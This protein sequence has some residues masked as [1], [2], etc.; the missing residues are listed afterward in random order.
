[1]SYFS[2]VDARKLWRLLGFDEDNL[3]ELRCVDVVGG[4]GVVG[5]GFVGSANGFVSWARKHNGAGNCFVGRNPRNKDGSV[6]H[7][8]CV[9]LDIDPFYEKTVGATPKQTEECVEAARSVLAR[10][11]GG[12]LCISGNGSLLVYTTSSP[13][14][15]GKE[16]EDKLRLFQKE[17][18]E[19][20][21]SGVKIDATQDSAR[22]IKLVGTVSVKGGARATR[23]L[24]LPACG[25]ESEE[26][27]RYIGSLGAKQPVSQADL[28]A[29]SVYPSRSEADYGFAV[30]FKQSGIGPDDCLELFA[31]NALGRNERRDDHIRI[32]EKVYGCVWDGSS[33]RVGTNT[34]AG[35]NGNDVLLLH[36]PQSSLDD[37]KAGLLKRGQDE[38]PE[39]PTGFAQ[40]DKA[41]HGLRRGEIYTIAARPA[42]GKSSMCLNI[43]RSLCANHRRVLALSTEMAYYA[44]WDR[45]FSIGCEVDGGAFLRGR[46]DDA[47]RQAV[48]KFYEEFKEYDFH[49]CDMFQPDITSVEQ[50]A[51]KVRP[52]VLIFDHIQHIGGGHPNEVKM[53]SDFTRGLKRL[54]MQRDCAVVVASQLRRP[55]QMMNFRS[56]QTMYSK[57]SLS[58]LKGCGT[59]EEESAFVLL[60]YHSTLPDY[61]GDKTTPIITAELAKNRFG[62]NVIDDLVFHKTVTKFKEMR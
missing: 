62:P 20:A 50:A 54:A 27:F 9:T 23:F 41:T 2:G 60:L 47:Q 4:A 48:D 29:R 32:I 18:Q 25:G 12:S 21:G 31:K 26:L 11:K 7:I 44:V 52:D 35:A 56:G 3:A 40:F 13:V 19:I 57:P 6:K 15:V 61:N 46:F 10:F 24:A 58:D 28:L 37:Y 39:L 55:Q 45:M 51:E 8:S 34:P 53:L 17:A 1:M 22:L 33:F 43:A 42:V 5:R 59:I 38:K 49:V 14:A 36:T 16:F 30:H